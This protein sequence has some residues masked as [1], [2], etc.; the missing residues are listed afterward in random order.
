MSQQEEIPL[1]SRHISHGYTQTIIDDETVATVAT[2][3]VLD[4]A[5]HAKVKVMSGMKN[6]DS[7]EGSRSMERL[8]NKVNYR[9]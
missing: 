7:A 6:V 2:V 1:Y 5:G 9:K 3:T 8:L 4:K